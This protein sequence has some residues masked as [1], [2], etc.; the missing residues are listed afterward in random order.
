MFGSHAKIPARCSVNFMARR[1]YG[2]N[3][4]KY[5][6][7]RY[8]DFSIVL[9][10]V[11]DPAV[12]SI[13]AQCSQGKFSGWTIIRGSLGFGKFHLNIGNTLDRPKFHQR[14][15]IHVAVTSI[16]SES[17]AKR[18]FAFNYSS[19]DLAAFVVHSYDGP[20]SVSLSAD[21]FSHQ[22]L[23]IGTIGKNLS[24]HFLSL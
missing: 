8:P 9:T 3:V 12:S 18:I 23:L 13:Q 15:R 22:S 14:L 4:R 11:A 20:Q 1:I 19:S 10:L 7:S 5:F 21:E 17:S 16:S 2:R 6:Y 24:K